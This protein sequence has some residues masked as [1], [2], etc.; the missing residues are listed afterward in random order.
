L[1]RAL[2]ALADGR[3]SFFGGDDDEVITAGVTDKIIWR[4]QFIHHFADQ[5][6]SEAQHIVGGDK[7]INIFE[8]ASK[9]LTRT[10][11]KHQPLRWRII[12][13]SSSSIRRP[14]GRPVAGR[15]GFR[16]LSGQWRFARTASALQY[17]RLGDVII[18][19][20]FQ[21]LQP[22]AALIFWVKKITGIWLVRVLKGAACG[23]L[24]SHQYL[25]A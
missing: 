23:K 16:V 10:S 7:P 5:H 11:I 25:A 4:A 24:H 20:Q 8:K 12:L 9:L 17:Q 22:V 2:Q 1:K 13:R 21:A 18:R 14:A 19:A 6:G 15:S 3:G